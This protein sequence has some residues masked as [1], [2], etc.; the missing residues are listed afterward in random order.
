MKLTN[1]SIMCSFIILMIF[2]SLGLGIAS[3]V[4]IDNKEKIYNKK[5]E[6]ACNASMMKKFSNLNYETLNEFSKYNIKQINYIEMYEEFIR[7]LKNNFNTDNDMIV[8]C[9][10]KYIVVTNDGLVINYLDSNNDRV[11]SSVI[12]YRMDYEGTI[13]EFKLDDPEYMME[14]INLKQLTIINTIRRNIIMEN[15]NSTIFNIPYDDNSNFNTI[16]NMSIIVTFNNVLIGNN[17]KINI[18]SFGG[19]ETKEKNMYYINDNGN[20]E[21]GKVDYNEEDI[22]YYENNKQAG[23]YFMPELY[24]H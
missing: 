2:T 19:N 1:L 4:K 22:L 12:P 24:T 14:E 13:Y 10:D 3:N 17:K 16:K 6:Y 11:W 23:K 9:L 21:K 20:Y 5:I 7:V 8:N 18:V 15:E